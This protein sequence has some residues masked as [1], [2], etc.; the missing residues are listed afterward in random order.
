MIRI[1]CYCRREIGDDNIGSGGKLTPRENE[2]TGICMSC[3]KEHWGAL[4]HDEPTL[5]PPPK[6]ER[7][8]A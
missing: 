1:C 6:K 4:D 2:T 8:Y 3:F 5:E 7:E